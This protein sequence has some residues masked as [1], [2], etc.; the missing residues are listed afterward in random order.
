MDVGQKNPENF[1][2]IL[3]YKR[4]AAGTATHIAWS[5]GQQYLFNCCSVE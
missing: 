4:V 2:Q 3:K 5:D 1:Y